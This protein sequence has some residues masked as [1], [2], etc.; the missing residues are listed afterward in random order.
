M[1]VFLV[2]LLILVVIFVFSFRIERNDN[3]ISPYE[4]GFDPFVSS[5][6]RFSYR[7]F[8]VSILFLIFDVEISLI[9]PLVYEKIRISVKFR[10]EV[11][12]VLLL[13]G[14]LYEYWGG[15]LEWAE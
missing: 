13:V 15:V 9:L 6:L 3:V 10:V 4:C 2:V 11:F 8:L 12:V 7:F 14:L 1:E 5:R